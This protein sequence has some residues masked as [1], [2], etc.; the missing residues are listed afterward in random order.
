MRKKRRRPSSCISRLILIIIITAATTTVSLRFFFATQLHDS[1]SYS[2]EEE[3][4]YNEAQQQPDTSI[5]ILS[6]LIP[7]H[8]SIRIINETFNSLSEMLIGLPPNTPIFISIDGLP[9]DKDTPENSN[10]LYGYVEQLRRRFIHDN[11]N[12]EILYNII[13]GHI[14]G[15]IKVALE[16]VETKFIYVIQHDLKFLYKHSD[17]TL[18]IIYLLPLTL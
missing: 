9:W 4:Y 17:L 10:R 18:Q 14:S 5:I 7:T 1:S 3:D 12:V 6:S 15:S 16:L 11:H 2:E 13:H 8:P